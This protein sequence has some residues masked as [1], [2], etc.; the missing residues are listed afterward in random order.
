MPYYPSY[1]PS[2]TSG[3]SQFAPY[4][5]SMPYAMPQLPNSAQMPIQDNAQANA[6]N[7][8]WVQ[9]EAAAKAY[10]VAAGNRVLLMDSDN[11]VIYIKS[12]DVN[13]RPQPMEIYDLVKRETASAE[14]VKVQTQPAYITAEDLEKRLAALEGSLSS[15]FVIRKEGESHG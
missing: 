2:L 12:T 5:G 11:P 14:S 7:F 1:Y 9:G 6:N 10:P 15:K 13:G 3:Q 4:Q 8:V